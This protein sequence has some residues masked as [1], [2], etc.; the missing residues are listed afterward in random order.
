M[1]VIVQLETPSA[2]DALVS[3]AAVPGVDALFVGPADLAATMGHPGQNL[4][5][6]VMERMARAARQAAEIGKPIG[7]LGGSAQAVV[8]Y[9][10]AGFD[11]VAL[12]ADLSL[13]M[14]GAQAALQALRTPE[15]EAHVHTLAEGTLTGAGGY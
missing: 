6:A 2:L 12:G 13:L 8:Q 10:A 4:H 7:T 1:G 3:I 9:R 11:F 5:P 14:K 15:G